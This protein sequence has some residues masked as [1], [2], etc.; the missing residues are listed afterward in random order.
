MNVLI[1]IKNEIWTAKN[2]F[3]QDFAKYLSYS[4]V[5]KNSKVVNVQIR[6]LRIVLNLLQKRYI[7]T[8]F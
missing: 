5:Q 6:S 8:S 4:E 2:I 1:E 7:G 3:Q